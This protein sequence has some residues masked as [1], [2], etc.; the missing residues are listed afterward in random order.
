MSPLTC[1]EAEAQLVRSAVRRHLETCPAC[2]A[3]HQQTQ[4]LI[5]LLDLH[6][7][8]PERLER[9]FARLETEPVRRAASPRV[10][11]FLRRAAALAALVLVT[12]GVTRLLG[13]H[14]WP[15]AGSPPVLA[16]ALQIGPA[17]SAPA[18]L[19]D[20]DPR[21]KMLPGGKIDKSVVGP[22]AA[23]MKKVT[24][25]FEPKGQTPAEFRRHL[26]AAAGTDRLPAPLPLDLQ[27]TLRNTTGH[28]LLVWPGSPTEVT[29]EVRGPGA[30]TVEAPG[31][32]SGASEPVTLAPGASHTFTFDRFAYHSDGMNRQVYLTEPG[33]YT[34]TARVR[35]AVSP[36][37]RDVRA[38]R[39]TAG[40]S[41]GYVTLAS[42][43]FP[44]Q[45][46]PPKSE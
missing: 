17:Q 8:E 12:V 5:G 25:A 11:P 29:L 10:L 2:T 39:D 14:P 3:A 18:P 27:V 15:E 26:R 9:L 7:Q 32:V 42:Q 4:Q 31:P 19:K 36:P 38:F 13:P 44:I 30:V 41:L 22:V 24:L 1:Q 23:A 33:D 35:A 43:P 28:D 45:V 16:M 40:R 6:F 46:E 21:E 37:P 20:R 34:V